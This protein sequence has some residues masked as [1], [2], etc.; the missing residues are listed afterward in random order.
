MTGQAWQIGRALRVIAE[1]LLIVALAASLAAGFVLLPF[2]L[3][4]L[5]A[6]AVALVGA[7]GLLLGPAIILEVVFAAWL[8]LAG[9]VALAMA[10]I[11]LAPP[12][13][14]AVLCIIS[15]AV[16]RWLARATALMASVIRRELRARWSFN[17]VA[18]R[19]AVIAIE[20]GI[21]RARWR[22]R[23][24]IREL[25][26]ALQRRIDRSHHGGGGSGLTANGR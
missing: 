10:S 2:Y 8:V 3:A 11:A 14:F 5:V 6:L 17:Q 23:H 13:A 16:L 1:P 18:I 20:D 7:A 26:E 12:L 25:E 22:A 19:T 24:E 9:I 4:A 15:A 21:S